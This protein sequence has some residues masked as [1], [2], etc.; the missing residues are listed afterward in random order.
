[1]EKQNNEPGTSF[2]L[3]L[4]VFLLSSAVLCLEILAS[5]VSSIIFIHNYAFMVVSLAILGLGC[6]GIYVFYRWR[7]KKIDEP[8]RE[9][10]LFSSLF[11]ISASLFIILI[12]ETAFLT[13]RFVYFLILSVPFFFAGVV[14]SLAFRLFTQESFKLYAADLIGAAFGSFLAIGILNLLG[15][16]N[17]ILFVGLLGSIA[18][19]IFIKG[20]QKK[21]LSLRKPALLSSLCLLLFF[22]NI[23]VSFLG[24]V[25]V[26][27]DPRKDLYIRL[28]NPLY[29]AEISETKWSAFGRTDLVSYKDEQS[30]KV[31][32]IDGAAG[33]SMYKFNGDLENPGELIEFLRVGFSGAFPFYFLKEGQK[34]DMLI[35]GPG[36]GKEVLIGLLARVSNITGVEV[37]KD[38]VDIVKKYRAYNGGIYTDFKN[39]NIVVNEGRSFLRGSDKKYDIIMFTLPVTKSSR[40]REGYTLTES[41]LFTVE[42]IK[43]YFGHLT[44]EGRLIVVLHH[45]HEMLRFAV[46]ALTALKEMG[47]E[48]QDA[49]EHIYTLGTEMSPLL[50]LKRTPFTLAEANARHQAMHLLKLDAPKSSYI[51][52]IEQQTI[53]HRHEGELHEFSMFSEAMVALSR[54]DI[55]LNDLITTMSHDISAPRDNKPFFFKHAIGLPSDLSSLLTFIVLINIFVIFIPAL[56]KGT[57]RNMLKPLA[58]F[59]LLGAGFML[60]EIS[61]FQK[62]TLYLGSPTISLAILL[63]SLLAGMG[64]GSYFGRRWCPNSNINRL[65]IISSLIFITII[66]LLFIH[67]LIL[68][69]FLGASILIK[70][71]LTCALLTPLG[72]ILGIP[73]PTAISLLKEMGAEAA[74]AWMYGV[75][76]TMSVLGSVVAI[77]VSLT[78]GF[79]AALILGALC[80]L[81]IAF[82]L[83]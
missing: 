59:M 80:Y 43:D 60:V 25:P 65:K 14:L 23:F 48:N 83:I 30:A 38:F 18:C 19:F 31:L 53:L 15:G 11:A 69:K 39:V 40:S 71:L 64:A 75:N 68:N 9:F 63:G 41:Y 74:I 2:T 17:G 5:R 12:T 32:F 6:G 52:H 51:P 61:F 27:R 54:G 4:G 16:V 77:C 34:D 67:P 47:I 1:M 42:S 78:F 8:Y 26:G 13:N 3:F 7:S 55:E 50:V 29:E 44:K 58:I 76:G 21:T 22:T 24:E 46:T 62:L 66:F 56:Y 28:N 33:T 82:I 73:F 81:A 36:G 79:S 20:R 35:I 10:S 37:N 49:M 70:G 72:F 57:A 45:P